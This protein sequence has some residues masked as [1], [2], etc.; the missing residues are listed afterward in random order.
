M[1]ATARFCRLLRER[2]APVTVAESLLAVE[3]L[4]HLDMGDRRQ[5]YFGLRSVLTGSPRDYPVF[6]EAFLEF[7]EAVGREG[8]VPEDRRIPAPGFADRRK[9]LSRRR[10]GV[11]LERWLRQEGDVPQGPE[12]ALRAPSPRES[13]AKRDFRDFDETELGEI[14]RLARRLA[15]RLSRRPGRRWAVD[16]RGSRV[17]LRGTVRRSLSTGGEAPE[18][19]FRSRRPRRTRIVALCDV[20]GSMDLYSRFLLQFLYALQ[21]TLGRVES[22]VFATGLS[23]VTEALKAGRYRRALERI[24]DEVRDFSGGT[25]I[26]E[27]LELFLE[28]WPELLDRRTVVLV[29]SDGWETGDPERLEATVR[30]L[31]ERAGRLLWLNP[32]MAARDYRPVTRGMEAVLP[33]VDGMLP[34]H[35]LASLETLA[36]ELVG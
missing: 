16:P 21:Q 33:L 18:L 9:R 15:R 14:L 23:R 12:A 6:H 29:L 22:F 11:S 13:L 35:N 28:G 2:G 25:R 19:V 30:E 8:E 32:L 27:C 24:G 34:I 36:R 20:S 26:G 1:T 31:G 10:P 7:W 17:H 5:V 4:E 3:A